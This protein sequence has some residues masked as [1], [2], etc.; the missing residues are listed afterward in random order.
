[1]VYHDFGYV[2]PSPPDPRDFTFDVAQYAKPPAMFDL[3]PYSPHIKDQGQE[4]SCTGFSLSSA[5]ESIVLQS[6][7][8]RDFS[9]AFIYWQERVIEKDTTEDAGASIRT[10]LKVLKHLGV[11][12]E[13]AFPYKA[14]DYAI[15]PGKEVY[16]IATNWRITAYH[17]L[18]TIR[19]VE[20]ALAIF[21]QPVVFGITVYEGM[22]KS[23]GSIPMPAANEEPLGGHAILCTGYWLDNDAPG[24]GWFRLNNSWGTGA[25]SL[26]HYFLPY[27]YLRDTPW[28]EMWT[29]R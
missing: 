29:L 15:A 21:H 3:G 22:E 6:G 4:G 9:A 7:A 12:P 10:G 8:G 25:G 19:S 1:M 2:K 27:A 14:G 5:R 11:P 13:E 18:R 26:G 23:T 16:T 28:M 17:R 20:T 24:G